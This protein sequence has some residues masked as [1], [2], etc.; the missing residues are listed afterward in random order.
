[1]PHTFFA[2]VAF[3]AKL[4]RC[5]E[6]LWELCPFGR[7]EVVTSAGAWVAKPGFHGTGRAFDLDGI[8]WPQT[9][10]VTL[11]D[12]FENMDRRF[13]LAVESVLRMH[14]GEVLNYNFNA[15]HRDHFHISDVEPAFN[16]GRTTTAFFL[17][18]A[19]TFVL[20]RRVGIDGAFGSGTRGALTAALAD[21]GISGNISDLSVYRRFLG[22]VADT[23]FRSTPGFE[24]AES[25][26]R[27]EAEREALRSATDTTPEELLAN[28][29]AVI[30]Q[31]LGCTSLRPKVEGAVTAFASHPEVQK[32]I[33]VSE[34][35][36]ESV[37][38][39]G[40]ETRG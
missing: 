23:V 22:A 21:L 11:R 30:E 13:Y 5:F 2:T 38:E 8:F 36:D 7:A 14:F 9:S 3:E 26:R 33:P 39:S 32:L 17:Q 1:M 29:Y 15:D 31:E 12:G 4:D 28:I 40:D 24:S 18:N 16:P 20:G 25:A 6:Q 34:S 35:D 27:S 19:L 10:F 37:D